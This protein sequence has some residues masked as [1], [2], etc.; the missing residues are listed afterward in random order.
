MDVVII[1]NGV[2]GIEA[3]RGVRAKDPTAKVTIVSEESDHFFSRTALMWVAAGQL[4]HRCIEPYPRDF[5]EENNFVRVRERAVG[6]EDGRVRLRSGEELSFDRLLIA[7]GSA[8]R[9]G[10]WPGNELDGVGHLVTM[11]DLE[12]LEDEL[13]GGPG[14]GGPPRA[15]HH[16]DA[17]T[18]S[19]RWPSMNA[20][21]LGSR[22][23]CGKAA[24]TCASAKTSRPW[25]AKAESKR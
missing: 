19:G 3:A 8:P 9:S 11:Q 15:D 16:L 7:C 1:G 22:I 12:W 18:G 20:S 24:S 23:A 25:K 5:Y 17:R 21:R 14:D 2:A 10:P 13:H 4:S 6:V